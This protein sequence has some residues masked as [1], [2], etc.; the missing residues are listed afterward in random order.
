M[1]TTRAN[2]GVPFRSG[3]PAEF[4]SHE[5][6]TV[7]SLLVLVVSLATGCGLPEEPGTATWEPSHEIQELEGDN[8]LSTNG[9]STNG[10]STNGLSTNGL[11]T[12]GLSTHGLASVSFQSWFQLSPAQSDEL[13]GYVVR[14]AAPAGQT[15]SFTDA[16]SGQ[17]YSWDGELGLAPGWASGQPA[18]AAEQQL[19][20]AC[21]AAH[22]NKY[23]VHI[24]ISVLGQDATGQ[25]IP[26]TDSELTTHPRPEACLFGNLFTGEGLYA[27][28]AGAVLSSS[29]SST[30]A[31]TLASAP[32]TSRSANCAPLVQVGSC[33]AYCT[34]DATGTYYTS[35]TYEG[36]TYQPL[37][38]RLRAEDIYQCGDGI[39]QITESCGSSNTAES[40]QAD[41]GSCP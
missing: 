13:M 15:L 21:L 38:T 39:C 26:Y 14:C 18:T 10:L 7:P 17:T 9:L 28:N 27:G 33:D 37:T 11:A 41:C 36:V 6:H 23:G 8:G 24:S 31:C 20:S 35:C 19:I 3:V 2:E 5:V 25:S 30:R 32:G 22:V 29:Q 12:N 1:T 16:L 4:H 40:C 34:L